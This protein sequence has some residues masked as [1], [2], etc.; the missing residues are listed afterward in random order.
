M[1]KSANNTGKTEGGASTNLVCVFCAS[2]DSPDS[3]YNEAAEALGREI[4]KAGYGLVYGGGGRGLM[5]RVACSVNDNNGDV[6]GII[7]RA[8][9]KIEGSNLDVGRT[10]LVDNMHERKRMM[11]DNAM[12][13]IALP[14]GLGTMEELLEMSTWSYLSIHAKPV[15]VVNTNGFYSALKELIDKAIEAGFIKSANRGIIQFCDTPKEAVAAIKT[16]TL[17]STRH[18]INW[19]TDAPM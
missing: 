19:A 1:S 2:S 10:I 15:I 17:P 4:A 12:A 9:T 11:N 13:F 8:L 16:Y 5:G 3:S 14:G 7:P 18:D 6:L